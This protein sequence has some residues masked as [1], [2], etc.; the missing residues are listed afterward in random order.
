[1]EILLEDYKNTESDPSSGIKEKVAAALAAA[2]AIPHGKSLTQSEMEDL[3]D[4]LFAC[5]GP[6]YSASGKPVI[7][8]ITTEELDKRFK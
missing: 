3:F 7:S 6:N 8:I 1:M 4:T 2:S 5:S